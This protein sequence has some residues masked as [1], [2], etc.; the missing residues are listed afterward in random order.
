MAQKG[1]THTGTRKDGTAQVC[2]WA[3]NLTHG[4]HSADAL[5]CD[6]AA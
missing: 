1:P 4:E 3:T 2:R 6:E 5:F